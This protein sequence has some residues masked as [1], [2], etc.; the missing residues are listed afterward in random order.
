MQCLSQIHQQLAQ[1]ARLREH[2]I[3][4]R[5]GLSRLLLGQRFKQSVDMTL[6]DT[7]QHLL[8]VVQGQTIFGGDGLIQQAQAIAHAAIGS[9]GNMLERILGG[10]KA[11]RLH[12]LLEL[13]GDL[14]DRQAT[15]IKLQT[16]RQDG[17]WDLLRVRGRQHK[18]DVLGRLF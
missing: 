17:H 4:H 18:F 12:N 16:P 2:L 6:L 3:N 10:L 7:A 8:N 9:H 11:L 1:V 5:H 13:L 15:Q 14:V